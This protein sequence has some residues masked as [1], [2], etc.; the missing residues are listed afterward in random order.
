MA[1]MLFRDLVKDQPAYLVGSAGV[2]AMPGQPA[3]K[4]TAD[5][6][7]E[8]GIDPSSFRSRPLTYEMMRDATHVF[9]MSTQHLLVMEHDFPEWMDKTYLVT[10]FAR[11]DSLRGRDVVDPIGM[12]RR[13]YEETR[14]MLVACLPSIAAYIDQ[15][16][17][18]GP[19]AD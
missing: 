5:L 4:H 17:S 18:P 14:D 8:A 1:E 3:S 10:E 7:R 13:A 9:A 15:T 19:S 16:T 12:G 6:L 11:D 2:G